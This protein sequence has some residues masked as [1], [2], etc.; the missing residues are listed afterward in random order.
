MDDAR[1]REE[2]DPAPV[3]GE[4]GIGDVGASIGV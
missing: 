1:V 2:G 3:G 4:A